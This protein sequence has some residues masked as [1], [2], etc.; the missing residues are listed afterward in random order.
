MAALGLAGSAQPLASG[1]RDRP[2]DRYRDRDVHRARQLGDVAQG[3]QRRELCAAERARPQG[4]A[5]G[6]QLRSRRTAAQRASLVARGGPGRGRAGTARGAHPGRR[7][8]PGPQRAGTGGAGRRGRDRRRP[9]DRRRRRRARPHPG[10]VRCTLGRRR[11][12]VGLCG[13][14]RAAHAW[15]RQNR[16]RAR[17]AYGRGR[18]LT[19]VFPGHAPRRRR[20]RRGRIPLCGPVRPAAHRAGGIRP[21]A[22]GQRVARDASGR[23]RPRPGSRRGPAN[24]PAGAAAAG[25]DAPDARR[26]ACAPGSV[27]GRGRRP[28]HLRHLLVAGARGRGARFVQSR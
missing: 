10:A 16:G 14:G 28:A 17:P 3:L 27:Q 26:R 5:R 6:K 13:A 15:H 24:A 22:R 9:P 11:G 20:V 12:G 23:R 7:L 25:S 21:P 8:P 18:H 1:G 4:D 2:R 19:R